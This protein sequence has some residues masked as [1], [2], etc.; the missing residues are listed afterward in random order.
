MW[1][2]MRAL[3]VN[4][5]SLYNFLRQKTDLRKLRHITLNKKTATLPITLVTVDNNA[6]NS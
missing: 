4:E 5:L 2:Q 1:S 6:S 3:A